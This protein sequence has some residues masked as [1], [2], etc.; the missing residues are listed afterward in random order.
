MKERIFKNYV[1]TLLGVVL[2]AFSGWSLYNPPSE[3]PLSHTQLGILFG[4]GMLLIF[5]KDKLIDLILKKA[6]K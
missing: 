5:A 4:V 3:S 1:S 6:E 2:I